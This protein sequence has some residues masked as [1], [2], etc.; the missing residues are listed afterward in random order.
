MASNGVN[1]PQKAEL[2][3]V[4]R[5]AEVAVAKIATS[6]S[7][8]LGTGRAA[9]RAI[10]ALAQRARTEHL[11]LRCVATST[12]SGKLARALG[13]AVADLGE[14][15]TVDL[16]F[17]GADEVD[18]DLRMIKGRG[19]AMT[20]EKRVAQAA[21]R[22]VYLVQSDKL[23]ARLGQSAPLPV[24]VEVSAL[25]TVEQALQAEGLAGSRRPG[26]DGGPYRTDGGNPVLDL[27]LPAAIDLAALARLLD[28]MPGVV[29][30]G[31]FLDEADEVLVEDAAGLVT[32]LTPGRG[33]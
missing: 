6:M 9:S 4:D 33:R 10:R 31:L 7:V 20:R 8:G 18:P 25:A 15:G 29:G 17:D 14:V 3:M 22:R 23:V 19:G 24:E 1:A 26:E 5:L 30:H 27:R 21:R 2:P 16:L 32:C 13:L 28:S 12:A 11:A